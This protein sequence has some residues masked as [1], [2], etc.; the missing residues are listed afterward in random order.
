MLPQT[1]PVF[2]HVI[3]IGVGAFVFK[4]HPLAVLAGA[5]VIMYAV[6]TSAT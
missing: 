4:G 1:I 5:L 3:A 2:V 6:L